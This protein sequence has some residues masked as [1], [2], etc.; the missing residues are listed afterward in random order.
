MGS[1]VAW[2]DSSPEEA[3]RMKR[4]AALFKDADTLDEL[5]MA[6][7]RDAF[8][9]YFFPGTSVAMTR[10]KY[11]LFV[12]WLYQKLDGKRVSAE[13]V[14][15]R[16]WKLEVKL[17]DELLKS[18][19]TRSVIG[20][21]S[22][23]TLKRYPSDIYWWPLESWGI[24][25]VSMSRA[26]YHQSFDALRAIRQGVLRPDDQGIPIDRKVVWHE[27]LPPAP[28]DFPENAR[29][30]LSSSEAAYIR[31]RI[32]N[33]HTGTLLAHVASG[34]GASSVAFAWLYPQ[35]ADL[36][37][38]LQEVLVL[39][40]RFA[41]VVMGAN[42]LYYLL[43]AESSN[44]P[45]SKR[46]KSDCE[47]QLKAWAQRDRDDLLAFDPQELWRFAERQQASVKQATGPFIEAFIRKLQELG[48]ADAIGTRDVRSLVRN[49]EKSVKGH[50][51]RLGDK[52]ALDRWEGGTADY[53]TY[54]WQT[55]QGL[56]RD[57]FDGLEGE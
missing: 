30:R 50:R 27:G 23:E 8:S 12:P 18:D 20:A 38:E 22:R 51:A 16:L 11:F 2:V 10:L 57:L 37:K 53:M 7:L 1:L 26:E 14:R 55:V 28:P 44:H 56:M 3:E 5:G 46:W 42:A 25:N 52:R 40:R 33:M 15:D 49:Q 13:A 9:N 36:P 19:D 24:R 48:P 54:R 41:S 35:F 34:P 29:L 39:A 4:V 45:N 47:Q 31:D 6:S 21:V 32:L 43:L 17:I